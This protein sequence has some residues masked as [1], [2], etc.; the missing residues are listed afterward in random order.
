MIKLHVLFRALLLC[1]RRKQ[2]QGGG[3]KIREAV[4][5]MKMNLVMITVVFLSGLC[6][7]V[8]NIRFR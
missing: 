4:R 1:K 8:L 6:L 5:E 3:E 7:T 2:K